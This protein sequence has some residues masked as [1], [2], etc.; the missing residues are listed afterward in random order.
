MAG[1]IEN[2]RTRLVSKLVLTV[3]TTF[4]LSM[5]TWA[6]FNIGYYKEQ[7]MQ[8]IVE[9]SKQIS[10]T[11]KLGTYYAMMINS[12]ND[13]NRIIN[14]ISKQKGIEN[15]RIYNKQGRI[16]F[17]NRPSEV[18]KITNIKD[19]A[20]YVCHR[21]EPP[22][23]KLPLVER[24]RVFESSLGNLN[25]G[26]ISPI[27][28]ET[29]CSTESCHVHSK[30]KKVIGAM[31]IVV[32]FED[33][34]KEILDYKKNFLAFS[35]LIFLITS[36]VI[37]VVVLR[38]VS[39]P[40]AKL[41]HGTHLISR[42]DFSTR[43]EIDQTDEMGQLAKAITEM[44]E[45][46]EKSEKKYHA[47]FKN[48]PNP[49]F[50]LDIHTFKILD[51]N[52]SVLP[53]YGYR[54]RD[55]ISKSFLDL[56]KQEDRDYCAFK[57][58]TSSVIN[59][60]KQINREGK[61]LYI[62]IR[63]SLSEYSG[64]K[65]LLVTTSDITKRLEAEQQLIQASKLATLGEMATGVAH[66]LNQPLSVIKTTSSFFIKKIDRK[67]PLEI[68]TL[69]HMLKKI[70]SNVD[71]ATRIINHMRQFARKSDLTT[72]KVQVNDVIERALELFSQQLEV[73]GIDVIW[74]LDQ[75]IPL[76][77]A[78]AGRLEQVFINLFINA[79]D[80]IEERWEEFEKVKSTTED[81]P[82]DKK[83]YLRTR[84]NNEKVT[85]ELEDTGYGIVPEILEKVFE[86][87]FT[88]KKPGKGTGLGLSISYGIVKECGGEIS[89][90]PGRGHGA[91]FI[92]EFPIADKRN[93][94]SSSNDLQTPK[95]FHSLTDRIINDRTN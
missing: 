11:I 28:N 6:Y 36:T 8:N 34:Y 40:I 64:Q 47:I 73:R 2:M 26:I 42:G 85:I 91:C 55:L 14:N 46:L 58:S 32:S 92:L 88:T 24:K 49:V 27:Y 63:V 19:R 79:R 3:G 68:K 77:Q 72:R 54:R 94:K 44:K 95:R 83:I 7:V 60:V 25:L 61:N 70:D 21:T 62:N 45:E 87:F 59:Q 31:D 65:V 39:R 76:I 86:P 93:S 10:N 81:K 69:N 80:A 56:F 22:L 53:V 4:L 5:S 23:E 20:C 71:R 75:N 15:I 38:F 66:E 48:I 90:V 74:E 78:D 51:C 9:S 84:H 41:I 35:V 43:L 50:V 16:K 12:R 18:G 17:S 37:I 89:V 13:I 67:Q 29:G 82:P 33:T 1:I 57:L 30:R 52:E